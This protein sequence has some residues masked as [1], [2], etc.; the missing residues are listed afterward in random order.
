MST[1]R[2]YFNTGASA[3]VTVEADDLDA[4][5]DAA[6]ALVPRNVCAQCG[7]WGRPYALDLGE[8]QV[9]ESTYEQDGE[10]VEVKK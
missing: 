5:I 9:D 6:Y 10:Y 7:G 1:F 3:S 4:A 2:I 8:W